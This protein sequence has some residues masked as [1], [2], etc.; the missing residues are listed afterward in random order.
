MPAPWQQRRERPSRQW[1]QNDSETPNSPIDVL[2]SRRRSRH[3][4]RLQSSPHSGRFYPF[5]LSLRK[6]RAL[7][8]TV[9]PQFGGS[10]LVDATVRRLR[11]PNWAPRLVRATYPAGLSR[12]QPRAVSS[13]IRKCFRRSSLPPHRQYPLAARRRRARHHPPASSA[14]SHGYL[15]RARFPVEAKRWSGSRRSTSPT[16]PVLRRLILAET[17]VQFGQAVL[18]DCHSMPSAI[19]GWPATTACDRISCSATGSASPVPRT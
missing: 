8:T 1:T 17:H 18:V 19:S 11:S 7:T 6:N 4:V 15:S 2:A 3:S 13:S 14:D 12:R 10:F 16:M 5:G 9:D